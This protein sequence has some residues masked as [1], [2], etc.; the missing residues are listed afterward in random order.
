MTQMTQSRGIPWA[1]DLRPLGHLGHYFL[2]DPNDPMAMATGAGLQFKTMTQMTQMT[3]GMPATCLPW[4]ASLQHV[5]TGHRPPTCGASMR[6]II[7]GRL[8]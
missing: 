8:A 3:Q 4:R 5:A 7:G 2:R 1:P 6:Q